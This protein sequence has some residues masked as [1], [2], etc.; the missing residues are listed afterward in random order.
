MK[1]SILVVADPVVSSSRCEYSPIHLG[2]RKGT[3]INS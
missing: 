1:I 3:F 2:V